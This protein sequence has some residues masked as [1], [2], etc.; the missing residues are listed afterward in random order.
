MTKYVITN[1][2]VFY[3]GFEVGS[4]VWIGCDTSVYGG[5]LYTMEYGQ[6]STVTEMVVFGP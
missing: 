1:A 6:L 5:K 4:T 3:N 2:A